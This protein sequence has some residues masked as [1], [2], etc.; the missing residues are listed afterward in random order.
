MKSFAKILPESRPEVEEID[1]TAEALPH[2]QEAA[3]ALDR[4]IPSARDM[5]KIR[6]FHL[7]IG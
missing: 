2:L 6:N 4:C 3:Q 1:G 5:Q 7:A